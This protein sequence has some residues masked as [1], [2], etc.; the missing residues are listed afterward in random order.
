[1]QFSIHFYILNQ[2]TEIH[3]NLAN[4]VKNQ[5]D[6]RI[7]VIVPQFRLPNYAIFVD[8]IKRIVSNDNFHIAFNANNTNLNQIFKNFA[9]NFL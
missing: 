3:Q 1:M 8:N 4:T 6:R 9:K 5:N 7:P 2:S